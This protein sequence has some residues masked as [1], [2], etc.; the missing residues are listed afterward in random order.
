MLLE[1][2]TQ[3]GHDAHIPH[4][5]TSRARMWIQF[6]RPVPMACGGCFMR[7][8]IARRDGPA[9]AARPRGQDRAPRSRAVASGPTVFSGFGSRPIFR[10][11]PARRPARFRGCIASL[12][13]AYISRTKRNRDKRSAGWPARNSPR[14]RGAAGVPCERAGHQGAAR[15]GDAKTS[16]CAMAL[17]LPVSSFDLDLDESARARGGAAGRGR[18]RSPHPIGRLSGRARL[19]PNACPR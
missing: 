5:G 6:R 17:D 4:A 12:T 16:A 10:T 15:D 14:D 13:S 11:D 8:L 1:T 19:R 9:R 3:P 7:P 2:N 18:R